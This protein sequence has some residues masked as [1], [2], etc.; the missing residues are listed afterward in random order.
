MRYKNEFLLDSLLLKIKSSK[1]YR[2]C[3]NHELLSLLSE[4]HLYKLVKELK[5]SYGVNAHAISTTENNFRDET[6]ANKHYGMLIFDEVKLREEV[7]FNS[8][9]LKVDGFVNFGDLTPE[10][11]KNEVANH[12]LVFMFVP[13]LFN[14]VQPVGIYASRN[15]TPGDIIFKILIQIIL[16]LEHA[17][18]KVIGFTADG[19]EELRHYR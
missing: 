1:G 9:S 2:H 13:L 7:A 8:N 16:Q 3:L 18:A 4:S 11:N 6:D 10:E 14:W 17:G 15:T 12:A 19:V 5:C